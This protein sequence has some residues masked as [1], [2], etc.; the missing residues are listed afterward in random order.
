MYQTRSVFSI[1]SA[2]SFMST[3]DLAKLGKEVKTRAW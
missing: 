2:K 1:G 3:N